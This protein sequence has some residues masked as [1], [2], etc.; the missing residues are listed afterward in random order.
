[1]YTQIEAEWARAADALPNEERECLLGAEV[2][3]IVRASEV[4]M[5]D[6]GES[7]VRVGREGVTVAERVLGSDGRGGA[8]PLH[9]KCLPLSTI[10]M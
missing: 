2:V 3:S 10:G 1:M 8:C 6:E 7:P 4:E 5:I 9:S